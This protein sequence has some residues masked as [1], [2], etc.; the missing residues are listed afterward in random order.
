MTQLVRV[1]ATLLLALWAVLLA[2]GSALA[3]DE[4]AA[5]KMV[6]ALG[7]GTNL[8]SM[9]YNFARISQ[10]QQGLAMRIGPKKADELLRSEL[11]ATVPRYQDEWD[12][13]L[14]AAWAHLMT[15]EELE[16]VVSERQQSPH[17]AKFVAARDQ[18]AI[19]MRVKSQ[20]LLEKLLAEVLL[21]T[22]EKGT[23]LK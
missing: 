7:L 9:T 10:T 1:T 20:P 8:A 16:S 6:K 2:P 5:L 17:A 22:F 23:A 13:N 19:S 12:R 18:A 11:A 15:A 14:A 4:Q 21:R 3:Q